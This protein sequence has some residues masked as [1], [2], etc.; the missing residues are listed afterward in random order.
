MSGLD[1]SAS[2]LCCCCAWKQQFR[3]YYCL[4]YHLLVPEM[5]FSAQGGCI[6]IIWSMALLSWLHY[7]SLSSHVLTLQTLWV[8]SQQWTTSWRRW[9]CIGS[10]SSREHVSANSFLPSTLPFQAPPSSCPVIITCQN[11]LA[12]QQL[13][14]A[15]SVSL[16]PFWGNLEILLSFNIT[17]LSL[18]PMQPVLQCNGT[19]IRMQ[20]KFNYYSGPHLLVSLLSPC[21]TGSSCNT[22]VPWRSV[23]G[24]RKLN[25]LFLGK[26]SK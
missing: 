14:L 10:A 24:Y 7:E 26:A 19:A 25:C 9:N 13:V 3:F 2:I 12:R 8:A 15:Y 17:T 5:S 16:L 22:V 23:V 20:E 18:P 1:S 11:C 4:R 6:L 21:I